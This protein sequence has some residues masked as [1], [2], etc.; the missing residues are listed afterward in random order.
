MFGSVP[1]WIGSEGRMLGKIRREAQ[2]P[3]N[4]DMIFVIGG[5]FH[6][7]KIFL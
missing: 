7:A 1:G 3:R 2:H 5:F 6:T 4:A